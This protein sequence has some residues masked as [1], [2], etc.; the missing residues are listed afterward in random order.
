MWR[1]PQPRRAVLLGALSAA[2]APALARADASAPGGAAPVGPKK[3]IAVAKFEVQGK[4]AQALGAGDV[5]MVL[6]DQFSTLL[7]QSGLFD[8]VDRADVTMTLKEQGLVPKSAVQGEAAGNPMDLLGAQVI[9]RASVTTF[10]QT[11]GGSFS[12]GLG[13][14]PLTG[15]LGRKSSKGVIG[16][17]IRLVD[18]TTGRIIAATHVQETAAAS[19]VS[20]GVQ[21]A[22][23]ATASQDAYTNTPLGQATE[24]A[25]RKAEPFLEAKLRDVAWTGRIAD[26]ADGA[27]FL[28]VGEQQGVK[29]GDTFAVSRV[30]RR[31]VD[32]GSGELL[33]VTEAP[34]GQV[35]VVEVK[36][37]FSRV[38]PAD[39]PLELQRGDIARYAKG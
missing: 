23:G 18:T 4:F 12:I 34:V 15:L 33:G 24:R 36:E 13:S 32:P 3:R 21:Q 31:I 20:V 14:G 2:V 39:K 7:T 22:N 5:G 1:S 6:A 9:V 26:V 25:F 16:I 17:D 29:V 27:A 11:D 19:S 8:V 10:D 37:R 30:G 28:N 38:A 35:T